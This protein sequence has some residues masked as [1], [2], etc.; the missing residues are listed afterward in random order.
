MAMAGNA[1]VEAGTT[2]KHTITTLPAIAVKKKLQMKHCAA[3]HINDSFPLSLQLD[4]LW[5]W[6]Y[7]NFCLATP[8]MEHL[9]K[10]LREKSNEP[11][12]LCGSP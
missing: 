11:E 6:G 3:A 10:G 8:P 1:P 9:P 5:A 4:G 12:P 7:S 2:T